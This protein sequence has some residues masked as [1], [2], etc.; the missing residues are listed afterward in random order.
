MED[1][2]NHSKVAYAF[3]RAD[4]Y[5]RH[6]AFVFNSFCQFLTTR[7]YP[8]TLDMPFDRESLLPLNNVYA[9]TNTY[10]KRHADVVEYLLRPHEIDKDNRLLTEEDPDDPDA[11]G[12]YDIRV[13]QG[14]WLA[15]YIANKAP[16]LITQPIVNHLLRF[17][18][19][20]TE[21]IGTMKL[22]AHSIA[23]IAKNC[24]DHRGTI[25][26]ACLRAKKY[27]NQTSWINAAAITARLENRPCPLPSEII[28]F[29]D[30]PFTI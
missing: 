17:A 11:T 22:L 8:N 30:I 27:G 1:T 12:E 24:P 23:E 14:S 21:K 6:S 18:F 7:G 19:K 2:S 15:V 28:L 9:V 25:I 16:N 5:Q 4:A 3:Q 26:D 20:P 10:Y 29:D 13:I